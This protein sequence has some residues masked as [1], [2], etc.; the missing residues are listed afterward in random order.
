MIAFKMF[1][2][3]ANGRNERGI[4]IAPNAIDDGARDKSIFKFFQAARGHFLILEKKNE[5]RNSSK[6]AFLAA[7]ARQ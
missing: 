1:G 3:R 6:N 7:I 5:C 2:K 4:S